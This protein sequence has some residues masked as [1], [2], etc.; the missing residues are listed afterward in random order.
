MIPKYEIYTM[1]IMTLCAIFAIINI[2]YF[3]DPDK[4]LANSISDSD[5]EYQQKAIKKMAEILTNYKW[6]Y[7]LSIAI[8]TFISVAFIL[9]L[10]K[11]GD[12][13][14]KLLSLFLVTCVVVIIML[15]VVMFFL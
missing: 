2:N 4:V 13:T 6:V 11:Y 15:S 5:V 14:H 12:I 8:L 1:V 9:L 7:E 10:L 3:K